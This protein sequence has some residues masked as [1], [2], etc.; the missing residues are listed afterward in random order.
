MAAA[1]DQRKCWLM[2]LL[3]V[4]E[5]WLPDSLQA[6]AASGTESEIVERVSRRQ[7]NDIYFFV[8]STTGTNCGDK[9]TY[10]ISEDQCVQDQELFKGNLICH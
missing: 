6:V 5:V 8:N 1:N 2:L 7:S 3:F 4:Y 10:L 9:N